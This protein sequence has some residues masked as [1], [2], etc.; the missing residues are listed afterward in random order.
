ML[1]Q[2]IGIGMMLHCLAYS[3]I[4]IAQWQMTVRQ[5]III[6]LH[7]RKQLDVCT[8]EEETSPVP[9]TNVGNQP[10]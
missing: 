4:K 8:T 2:I 5:Q 7:I 3:G 6:V 1:I 10:I 9:T